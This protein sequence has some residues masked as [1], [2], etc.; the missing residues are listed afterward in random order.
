MAAAIRDEFSLEAELVRLRNGIF[1]VYVDGKKIF[2]KY[3]EERFPDEQEILDT[4]STM[5]KQA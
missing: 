3:E 4:I 1:K 5:Q 2:D